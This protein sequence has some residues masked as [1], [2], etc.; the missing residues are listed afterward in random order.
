MLP[1]ALLAEAKL[2]M[3]DALLNMARDDQEE[4]PIDEDEEIETIEVDPSDDASSDDADL[5]TDETLTEETE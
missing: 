2:I 5:D 4:N 3:T 1:L